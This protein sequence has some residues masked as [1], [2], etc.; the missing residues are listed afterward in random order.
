MLR[1]KI[2]NYQ[3]HVIEVRKLVDTGIFKTDVKQV[4]D[5][6]R[7]SKD[8][9]KLKDLMSND[10]SYAYL[11]EDAYDMVALY[12]GEEEM[13]RIKEKHKKGG[14]V[15]MCQGLR[16]WMEDERNEGRNEGIAIGQSKMLVASVESVMVKFNVDLEKACEGVGTTVE[17]YRKAKAGT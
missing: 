4:F 1:E 15:D 14:K 3:I 5:F 13:F 7:F 12:A 11:E 8:K 16:E 17:E 2:G 6:I 9:G 10:L